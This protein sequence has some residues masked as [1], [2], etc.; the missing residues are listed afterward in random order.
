[1]RFR[2]QVPVAQELLQNRGRPGCAGSGPGQGENVDVVARRRVALR[3]HLGL[4]RRGERYLV[5]RYPNGCCS[6]PAADQGLE[7]SP[8]T[9]WRGLRLGISKGAAPLPYVAG[10]S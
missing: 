1:M 4:A 2:N 10:R 5:E 3:P 9:R 7:K 8:P 6:T